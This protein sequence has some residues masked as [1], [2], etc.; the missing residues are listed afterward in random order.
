MRNVAE[1][2]S[3]MI[4]LL[5]IFI[6]KETIISNNVGNLSYRLP[7]AMPSN[8]IYHF[9]CMMIVIYLSLMTFYDNSRIF[10]CYRLE[11]SK[12]AVY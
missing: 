11:T 8:I 1:I 12:D 2:N 10:L 6:F 7:C 3:D 5:L 9:G 4:N